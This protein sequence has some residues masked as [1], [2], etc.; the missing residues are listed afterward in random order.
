MAQLIKIFLTFTEPEGSLPCSEQPI[1]GHS[2]VPHESSQYSHPVPEQYILIYPMIYPDAPLFFH[3]VFSKT[4]MPFLS[5]SCASHVCP[6][7]L[8][9]FNM[10]INKVK[11][12]EV[13]LLMCHIQSRIYA[14]APGAR[15]QG[16][17]FSG[18]AY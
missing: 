7:R 8:H 18:A 3:Q 4:L 17:K 1:S 16:C 2:L 9:N 10:L 6:L 12:T 11:I 14:R 5:P 15:A 13:Y